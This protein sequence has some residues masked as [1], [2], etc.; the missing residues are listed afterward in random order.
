MTR[1]DSAGAPPATAT[2]APLLLALEQLRQ[3]LSVSAVTCKRLAADG[4]LPPGAVVHL[5]WRRLFSRP[6]IE[7]WVADGCPSHARSGG[8]RDRR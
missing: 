6:I 2:L 5:G 8:R 4:T 7:K 1:P 3:L